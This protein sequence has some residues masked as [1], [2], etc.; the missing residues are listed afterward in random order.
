MGA[1]YYTGKMSYFNELGEPKRA[2]ITQD[3]P[4]NSSYRLSHIDNHF[5]KKTRYIYFKNL[6]IEREMKLTQ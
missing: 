6:E 4:L 3:Y 5:I 1:T 2:I